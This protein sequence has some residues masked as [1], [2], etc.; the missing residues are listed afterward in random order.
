[1]DE[2]VGFFHDNLKLHLADRPL[3]GVVIP[4]PDGGRHVR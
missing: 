4:L 3:N 1:M 2:A